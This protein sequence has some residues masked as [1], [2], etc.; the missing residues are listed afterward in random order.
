MLMGNSTSL[1]QHKSTNSTDQ[2]VVAA[3]LSLRSNYRTTVWHFGEVPASGISYRQ[4]GRDLFLYPIDYRASAHIHG[5]SCLMMI[6]PKDAAGQPEF[7]VVWDSGKEFVGNTPT[8]PFAKLALFI[9]T[10]DVTNGIMAFGFNHPVVQLVLCRSQQTQPPQIPILPELP[11]GFGAMQ[12]RRESQGR[13][14]RGRGGLRLRPGSPTHSP[15]TPHR[16]A[17]RS[18]PRRVASLRDW[19]MDLSDAMDQAKQ[20][21]SEPGL[22]PDIAAA[23][24][25]P[26]QGRGPRAPGG[27]SRSPQVPRATRGWTAFT[28]FGLDARD[29]VRA[30]NPGA[31]AADIE[32]LV[33]QRWVQLSVEERLHYADKA[34]GRKRQAAG[35]APGWEPPH[36][37][38]AAGG[39]G[40]G[41]QRGPSSS[42]RTES[43]ATPISSYSSAQIAPYPLKR[44]TPEPSDAPS[45]A[46]LDSPSR[47]KMP[48]HS[49]DFFY[50]H[51]G[52][53]DVLPKPVK[54]R[55]SAR[56]LSTDHH[57]LGSD[58]S[59]NRACPLARAAEA[60]P[61]V[62]AGQ[63]AVSVSRAASAMGVHEGDLMVGF[64]GFTP[65]QAVQAMAAPTA[66]TAAEA[67]AHALDSSR[68]PTNDIA[69]GRMQ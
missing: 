56:N 57:P 23:D 28:A 25:A 14:G 55:E 9:G 67:P 46:T 68:R 30:E 34:A 29:V 11:Q 16:L 19:H 38:T 8:A 26:R 6:R 15:Q 62:E 3:P 52:H 49:G 54:K 63:E 7:V 18:P 36:P 59:D 61:E 43:A 65:A 33:G 64:P 60:S 66:E 24:V 47:S 27:R 53:G 17:Q 58:G 44:K 13:S 5:Q 39:V 1:L 4:G 41:L 12:D 22:R 32:K 21:A 20:Y 45:E 42:L 69:Q 2:V 31:N 50:A 48:S 35:N 10:L 51:D 40:E 37:A